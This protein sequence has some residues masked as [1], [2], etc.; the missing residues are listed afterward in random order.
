MAFLNLLNAPFPLKAE[1][2]LAAIWQ[3]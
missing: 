3:F 1:E 2:N